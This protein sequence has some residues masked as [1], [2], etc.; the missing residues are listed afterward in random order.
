MV[1]MVVDVGC[2]P[3]AV[4][5]PFGPKG[6]RAARHGGGF[7]ASGCDIFMRIA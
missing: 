3:L 2:R 4:Q 1:V 6:L 5:V 7:A